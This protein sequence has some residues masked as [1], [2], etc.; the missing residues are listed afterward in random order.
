MALALGTK[1]RLPDGRVGTMC[2]R[3][4]DGEGGVFGEHDFSDVN[5]EGGFSDDLPAPEFML[6]EKAVEPLLQ[7]GPH[8]SDVECVGEQYTFLEDGL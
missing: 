1:I 7:K 4:L 5:L 2:W 3:H 6:R 8:R